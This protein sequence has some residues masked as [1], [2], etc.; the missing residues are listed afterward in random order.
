[1]L[2][3][4]ALAGLGHRRQRLVVNLNAAEHRHPLIEQLRQHPQDSRFGL[5]AQAEEQQI[6]LG[7]NA[8]D[9]LRDDR[10]AI[11]DDAGEKLLPFAELAN[12]I[13]AKFVFDGRW[14]ISTG[15]QL[16]KRCGTG[17]THVGLYLRSY[18]VR[19]GDR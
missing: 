10:I 19:S 11:P 1:M 3:H 14:P 2:G 6:V 13:P 8:V 15:L 5:P 4:E 7:K 18:V 12:D 17:V 9:D 16:T